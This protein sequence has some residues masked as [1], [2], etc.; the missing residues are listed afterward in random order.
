L[1]QQVL[2]C[3]YCLKLKQK[4]KIVSESGPYQFGNDLELIANLQNDGTVLSGGMV[5]S[6]ENFLRISSE[7]FKQ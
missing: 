5:S 7:Y 2:F 3:F 4:P 6:L 1:W